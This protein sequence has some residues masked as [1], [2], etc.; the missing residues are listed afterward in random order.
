VTRVVHD[1]PRTRHTAVVEL[2]A[3]VSAIEILSIV[4]EA[5]DARRAELRRVAAREI[6]AADHFLA[7]AGSRLPVPAIRG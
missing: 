5:L 7:R 3:P 1:D 2:D 6:S 4:V